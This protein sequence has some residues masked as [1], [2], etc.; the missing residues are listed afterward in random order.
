MDGFFSFYSS[1]F[2]WSYL[3]VKDGFFCLFAVSFF[4]SALSF[5]SC[6]V[7]AAAVNWARAYRQ[8]KSAG[9]PQQFWS[10]T[11]WRRR[12]R[13]RFAAWWAASRGETAPGSTGCGCRGRAS[14]NDIRH[15]K[16]TAGRSRTA[17]PTDGGGRGGRRSHPSTA[18][19]PGRGTTPRSNRC[20]GACP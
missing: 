9:C 4:C 8:P 14:E 5:F 1:F 15:P 13:R 20:P 10:P 6:L 17:A 2:W 11:T 18:R 7:S 12:R 16:T 19:S 3:K